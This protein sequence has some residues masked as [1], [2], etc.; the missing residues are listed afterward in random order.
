MPDEY[1]VI[2]KSDAKKYLS[3]AEKNQLEFILRSIEISKELNNE[4]KVKYMVRECGY[5]E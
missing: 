3:I 1:I 5:H 2:S 4:K